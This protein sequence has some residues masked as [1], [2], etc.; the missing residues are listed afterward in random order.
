[1]VTPRIFVKDPLLETHG[2]VRVYRHRFFT[3][4]HYLKDYK[5]VPIF[6]MLT[7]LVGA[8]WTGLKVI[9]GD[10]CVLIHAHWILPS[11]LIA[12]ILARLTGLPF[13]V[14]ARGSDVNVYALKSWF[15]RGLGR[16]ALRHAKCIIARSENLKRETVE[17]FRLDEAR[18]HV[19]RSGVDLTLFRPLEKQPARAKLGMVDG[20]DIVLFVGNLSPIKGVQY[21]IEALPAV[22][23][24]KNDVLCVLVGDGS[25][26]EPLERRIEELDLHHHVSFVGE[27]PHEKIPLWMNAADILVVPSLSEGVPNVVVEALACHLPVVATKVGDIPNLISHMENGLLIDKADPEDISSALN[28]LLGGDRELYGQIKRGC[29]TRLIPDSVE[30]EAERNIAVYQHLLQ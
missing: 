27:Q 26:R 30:C 20:R 7:Y 14:S 23:R 18:V 24:S 22:S 17:V 4:N 3:A 11:G 13:V 8:V 2:S 21:L 12:L 15:L 5:R 19:I 28:L 9:R 10:H 6:R 16:L 25:M 1:V 29:T